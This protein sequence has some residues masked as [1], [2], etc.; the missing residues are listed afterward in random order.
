MAIGL[1]GRKCG[2]TRVFT[3]AGES[4]PVTVIEVL[5][6]RVTQVKTTEKDGYKAVQV[7]YGAKRPQLVSKAVAGHY[8]KAGV[9]PG[10]ALVEFRVDAPES[11]SVQVGAEFKADHFKVGQVVDVTGTTIGKGFAGVMKRWN[12]R[13]LEASHGVS[14][15][16][17][18]HGSTGQRQ[19]PGKVFAGK[20]MAGHMGAKQITQ[21]NLTVVSTDSDRGLIFLRGAVPGHN[22]AYL[23]VSDATKIKA[24]KDLPFPAA[25]RSAK[26][27]ATPAA[28]QAPSADAGEQK[29]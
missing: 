3:D 20:K 27:E 16:H 28:E 19:D 26:A 18:S 5:P 13:G 1:V 15:S 11:D 12:F 21:Q 9:A 22:G 24:P 23:L 14:V 8:A 2:M 6:N 17:R 29:E 25:L 7:S 10:R 4:V